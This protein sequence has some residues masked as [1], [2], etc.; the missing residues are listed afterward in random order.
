MPLTNIYLS[1]L[2][3]FNHGYAPTLGVKY[4]IEKNDTINDVTFA[5]THLPLSQT[6]NFGE[7]ITTETGRRVKAA[8]WIVREGWS[9]HNEP[10]HVSTS[11]SIGNPPTSSG[12]DWFDTT[13]IPIATSAANISVQMVKFTFD[14]A[15]L[16]YADEVILGLICDPENVKE[17]TLS[18]IAMPSNMT[19]MNP[20]YS[21]IPSNTLYYIRHTDPNLD[22]GLP[23]WPTSTRGFY[24][25]NDWVTITPYV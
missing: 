25:E 15:Q 23:D 21:R 22:Y 12:T 10:D 24:L 16:I 14:F 9:L 1:Q 3:S 11:W 5:L 4:M 18:Y 2:Q 6:V 20:L 17:G 8:I 13:T 19:R 7:V